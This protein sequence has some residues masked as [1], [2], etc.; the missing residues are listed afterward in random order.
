MFSDTFFTS[1]ILFSALNKFFLFESVFLPFI[2]LF[3]L[4]HKLIQ[5][6]ILFQCAFIFNHYF[7]FI[8]FYNVIF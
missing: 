7:L 3:L 2:A 6:L 1:T 5:F 8:Q 4:A